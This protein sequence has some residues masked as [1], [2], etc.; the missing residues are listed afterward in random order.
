MRASCTFRLLIA[1]TWL[2]PLIA[3]VVAFAFYDHSDG[4]AAARSFAAHMIPHTFSWWQMLAVAFTLSLFVVSIIVSVG[5]WFFRR[6]ARIIYLPFG[7]FYVWW[8]PYGMP[9]P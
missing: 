9:P 1:L 2:M 8:W 4:D 6:W 5:L 3:N 7:A